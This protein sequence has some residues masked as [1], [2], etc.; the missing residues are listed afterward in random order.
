VYVV[1]WVCR[2][3]SRHDEYVRLCAVCG[4]CVCFC[5]RACECVCTSG[6]AGAR[7]AAT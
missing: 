1:L 2:S 5:V 6:Q 3:G 7:L 4:V